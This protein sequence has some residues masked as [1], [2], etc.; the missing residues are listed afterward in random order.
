M[1]KLLLLFFLFSIAGHAQSNDKI[2]HFGAG[3]ATGAAGAFIAHELSGGNKWWSIAGA[4]G[5]SL[6]AGLAKEA[7][8]KNKGGPWD[9]GDVVHTVAGGITVGI[10][11][12]I[13][14][15]RKKG[16]SSRLPDTAHDQ[17]VLSPYPIQET[18]PKLNSPWIS[19]N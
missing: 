2:L 4:V 5:G 9:N 15:G 1:K 18:T 16:K 13:F 12:E 17:F 14:S 7:I 10:A 11:I 3:V 6:M 19:Q 8:D